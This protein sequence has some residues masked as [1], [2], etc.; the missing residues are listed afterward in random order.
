MLGEIA[1][2]DLLRAEHWPE[3]RRKLSGDE[4]RERRFAVA[5][6]A[7]QRDAVVLV[8]AQIEAAEARGVRRHSRHRAASIRNSGLAIIFCGS[9][10]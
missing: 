2:I 5:V 6:L 3:E 1:D 10:K 4:L 8:D 9:G 7:Q